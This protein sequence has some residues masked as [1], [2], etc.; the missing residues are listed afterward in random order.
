MNK[1]GMSALVML[2]IAVVFYVLGLALA[3]PLRQITAQ[4]MS[5]T[6]LNCSTVTS[7]QDKAVCRSMDLFQPFYVG[8]IFGFAGLIIARMALA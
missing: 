5:S 1:R 4:A 8:L 7:Y 3:N 2:M 6:E